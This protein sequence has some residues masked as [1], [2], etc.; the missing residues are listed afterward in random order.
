MLRLIPILLFSM[1]LS[2]P[3]S[4]EQ[5]DRVAQNIFIEFSS[6]FV[7]TFGAKFGMFIVLNLSGLAVR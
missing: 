1:I 3:I 2:T 6:Y 5:A 4:V 7:L